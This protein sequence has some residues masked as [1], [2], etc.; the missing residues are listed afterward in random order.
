MS[1]SYLQRHQL[2]NTWLDRAASWRRDRELYNGSNI[3]HRVVIE[4][5]RLILLYQWR[6]A[7]G[8]WGGKEVTTSLH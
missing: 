8:W 6:A 4:T 2:G 7:F 1:A 5:L 3:T